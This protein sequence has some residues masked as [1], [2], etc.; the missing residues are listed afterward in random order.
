MAVSIPPPWFDLLAKVLLPD[1]VATV[2]EDEHMQCSS[3]TK[4]SL[5]SAF[6]LGYIL[7]QVAGGTLAD[8]LGPVTV[9]FLAMLLG[10][11]FTILSGLAPSVAFLWLSHV[12]MGASQGP[13]FPTSVAFLAR[14]LPPDERALGS[15][16][17]DAGITAG[18][19]VALPVSG[20]LASALG[21]RATLYTW[22]AVSMVFAA[23][24]R[25]SAVAEPSQCANMTREERDK[26]RKHDEMSRKA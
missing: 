8:R 15:S 9:I 12:M 23:I 3:T 17:L 26:W 14:W 25:V 2:C 6:S 11:V 13:L 18:S 4:G 19:L 21:W 10:A 16:F 22:G 7:T 20:R 1:P 24:W 5:L